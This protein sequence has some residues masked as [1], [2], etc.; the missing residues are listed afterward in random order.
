MAR[1]F[2][3]RVQ[4]HYLLPLEAG[5][6]LPRLPF[7]SAPLI[8]SIRNRVPRARRLLALASAPGPAS[9][10]PGGVYVLERLQP[11][12]ARSVTMLACIRSLE[13]NPGI[14]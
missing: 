4:I 2:H 10:A 11:S 6:L 5:L 14:S 12:R 13:A 9:L 7:N 3:P 8:F 1:F